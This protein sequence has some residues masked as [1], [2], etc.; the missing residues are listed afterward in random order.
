MSSRALT[1]VAVLAV[2]VAPTVG[3]TACSSFG[4]A[5]AT[6]VDAGEGA[7][8]AADAATEASVLPGDGAPPAACTPP[9]CEGFED[10]AW[11]NAWLSPFG[12]MSVATASPRT[13]AAALQLQLPA[14]STSAHRQFV[15]LGLG[16]SRHVVATAHIRMFTRGSGEVDLFGL[17]GGYPAEGPG[18]FVVTDSK[19]PGAVTV[20]NVAGDQT[21]VSATFSD[22]TRVTI[23]VDLDAGGYVA[24]IEGETSKTGTLP[25]TFT[26]TRLYLVVGGYFIAGAQDA[27]DVRFDDLRVDY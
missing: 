19:K 2:A 6:A 17:T 27:W 16:S 20:E 22:W 11:Q 4:E 13:G 9:R 7:D 10:P 8:A 15:A 24:D 21:P 3:A 14:A 25:K 1:V 5:D 12:A 26:A 23:T 18:I